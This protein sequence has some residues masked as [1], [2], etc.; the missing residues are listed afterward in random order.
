M[1]WYF[2]NSP[3]EDID[4]QYIAFVYLITNNLDG[5]K[6]IGKKLLS[7]TKTKTVKGKKKKIKS[8]SDW[9]TYWSSSDLLKSD[10]LKY[11]ESNFKR[12]ILHF[13]K[14]KGT[15]NY[16]EAKEQMLNEVLENPEK[17]YNRQIQCRIHTT[18]I[19]K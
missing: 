10:V 16:F 4:D 9:K 3:I 12:E 8:E 15:A 14:T 2:N 7:F 18:H 5:R 1:T 13:C 19:K 17:W 11:G 6:Y